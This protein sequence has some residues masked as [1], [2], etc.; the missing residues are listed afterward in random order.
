MFLI[1]LIYLIDIPKKE[2][3]ADNQLNDDLISKNLNNNEE[4]KFNK[5]D[6]KLEVKKGEKWVSRSRLRQFCPRIQSPL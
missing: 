6:E 1:R 3:E 5:N 4:I 2:I